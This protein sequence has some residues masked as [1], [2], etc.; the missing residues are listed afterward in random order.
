MQSEL[1]LYPT[2][3]RQAV[4]DVDEGQSLISVTVPANHA[5]A[6]AV[7]IKN[8]LSKISNVRQFD[9]DGEELVSAS[10]VFSDVT[11]ATMLKGLRGKEGITQAELAEKLGVTQNMISDMESGKRNISINMAKRIGEVFHIPYK[12]FL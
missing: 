8:L 12:L 5:K 11:P 6:I 4:L 2:N 1:R 9:E 10:E 7:G 3:T